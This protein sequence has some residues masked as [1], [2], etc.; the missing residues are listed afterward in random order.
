MSA[1]CP[2]CNGTGFKIV[3]REEISGAVRWH[4]RGCRAIAGACSC[5]V[6]TF[7]R[8]TGNASCLDNFSTRNGAS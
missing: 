4:M 6:Q 7:R 1:V 3:E 8:Y 2:D 5:R